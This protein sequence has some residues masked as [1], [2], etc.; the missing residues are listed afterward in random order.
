MT[1]PLPR[2]VEVTATPEP[3]PVPD[4]PAWW[5][6]ALEKIFATIVVLVMQGPASTARLLA[7][8]KGA[9]A[10]VSAPDGGASAALMTGLGVMARVLAAPLVAAALV[11]LGVGL[12][13]TRGLLAFGALKPDLTRLSPAA[14]LGRAFGGQAALQVGKGLLKATLVGV[15]AWLTVR[16]VLA[17]LAGLAGAPIPRLVGAMGAVSARLAE[18]VALV[19]LAQ[20]AAH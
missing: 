7:Y 17:G 11:A 6:A 10:A 8:W 9:F 13:Q 2:W 12:L 4:R 3:E 15:L 1:T 19:A 16:P 14:G 5:F 18:R 20:G